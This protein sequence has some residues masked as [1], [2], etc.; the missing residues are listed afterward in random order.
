MQQHGG[1]V[2]GLDPEAEAA[3]ATIRGNL[4]TAEAAA[5]EWAGKEARDWAAIEQ[6]GIDEPVMQATGSLSWCY[7]VDCLTNCASDRFDSGVDG[8]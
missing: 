1:E 5:D 4:A 2:A 8:G 3:I 6:A 7:V